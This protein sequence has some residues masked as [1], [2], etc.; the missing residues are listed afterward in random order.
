MNKSKGLLKRLNLIL[1]RQK[2]KSNSLKTD[3]V[4]LEFQMTQAVL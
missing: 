4:T 2:E 1:Q 3:K